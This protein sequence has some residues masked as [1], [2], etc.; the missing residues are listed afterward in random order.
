ML[1]IIQC[2]GKHCKSSGFIF[3]G[4]AFWKPYMGQAVGGELDLMALIG[5]AELWAAIQWEKST[6]LRKRGVEKHF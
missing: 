6:W 1:K 5:G 3:N 2:S 4:W